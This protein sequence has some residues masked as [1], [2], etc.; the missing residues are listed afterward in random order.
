MEARKNI[1]MI[2]KECIN[3]ILKHAECTAIKITVT[4]L[5]NHLELT[6]SD[7]G[8]GFDINAKSNRNGLKNIKK[9]AA[10]I[11]GV[12]EVISEPGKGTVTRLVVNI[13]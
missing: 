11:D 10:E 7:N 12:I 2:F 4:R 6:I 1:F 5:N 3:N 13:I 9:R 8:K